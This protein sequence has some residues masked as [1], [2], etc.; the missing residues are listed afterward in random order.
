M[1]SSVWLNIYLFLFY[2]KILTL[3]KDPHKMC[4]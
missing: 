2:L 1:V 4:E 3:A